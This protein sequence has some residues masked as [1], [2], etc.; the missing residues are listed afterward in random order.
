MPHVDQ[1]LAEDLAALEHF[2]VHL[3]RVEEDVVRIGHVYDRGRVKVR[4]HKLPL[5]PQ[6]TRPLA[7]GTRARHRPRMA[8]QPAHDA[9]P[10]DHLHRVRARQCT[11]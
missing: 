4:F 5:I 1:S 3:P 7:L 9:P 11:G 6:P 10:Q 2:D 8:G